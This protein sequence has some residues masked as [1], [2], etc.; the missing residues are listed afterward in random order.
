MPGQRW[1]KDDDANMRA[2]AL[3]GLSAGDIAERYK[4]TRNAIIGRMY[5]ANG[6]GLLRRK[7]AQPLSAEER[8]ERRRVRDQLRFARKLERREPI[9]G[10]DIPPTEPKPLYVSIIDLPANGCSWSYE[11]SG[12]CGQPRLPG[13]S[14]CPAHYKLSVRG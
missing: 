10:R 2:L 6:S 12:Y 1:T 5:R 3:A 7:K 13:H 11:K 9:K 4:V 8:S 14:L